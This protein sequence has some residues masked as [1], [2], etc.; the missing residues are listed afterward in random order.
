MLRF[1]IVLLFVVLYLISALP[2]FGIT[3]L[4][5]RK[6][7][8][9]ASLIEFHNVQGAFRIVLFLSGVRVTCDGKENIP[10][11]TPVLY[12]ANHRG[13]FDIVSLYALVPGITGFIAKKSV[14]HIPILSF[15]MRRL[16]CL[17]L[18][19]KDLRKGYETIRKS[20]DIIK[21]GIS[22]FIFPEGTR[23]RNDDPT[24][25]LPFHDGSFKAAQRTGCPVIPVAITGA[26][27]ILEKQ[28]PR[29]RAGSMHVAFGKPVLYSD[30]TAEEKKHVGDYFSNV[31][32]DMI[33]KEL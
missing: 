11:G 23:N 6:N 19:R 30:L 20:F 25:L 5:G 16:F 12:T 1:L 21:S 14:E 28:F 27:R 31:L 7:P 32:T 8:Q 17:F 24:V 18:D 9:K 29:I 10:E 26:D 4:I 3:W 22:L 33:R 15:I 2:V 13:I